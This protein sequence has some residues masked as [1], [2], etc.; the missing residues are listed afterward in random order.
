[1]PSRS[2]IALASPFALGCKAIGWAHIGTRRLSALESAALIE[3]RAQ[4]PERANP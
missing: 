2:P 3:G 1:M 4:W